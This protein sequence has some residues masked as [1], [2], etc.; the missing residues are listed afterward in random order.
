M[1]DLFKSFG[2]NDQKST[3]PASSKSVGGGSL[4]EYLAFDAKDR[5]HYFEIRTARGVNRAPAYAYLLDVISDGER[6][7]EI[8]LLFSFMVVDIRGKNLKAVTHSLINRECS[9]IQDYS[10]QKFAPPKPDEA[11]IESIEITA[12]E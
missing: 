8:S 2:F 12:R 6:G 5:S 9:F 11:V 7:T 4:P 1:T 3:K 10:S